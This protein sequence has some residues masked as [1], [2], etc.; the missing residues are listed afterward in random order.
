MLNL[1]E[2]RRAG[3]ILD[4][5]ISGSV[6]QR[7][8]QIDGYR[9][10]ILFY[11]PSET[12]RV[13]LSCRPGFARVSCLAEVPKAPHT[14]PSFVQY[15]RAHLGR[16]TCSGVSVA[17][18]DR[19]LQ[20]GIRTRDGAFRIYLSIL[21]A[22]SNVYLVDDRGVLLH[23]MRPLVRTRR[24][25]ALGQPWS[26]AGGSAPRAGSD[27]WADIADELFLEKIEE[28]YEQLEWQEEAQDLIRRIKSALDR[29]EAQLSR[30]SANLLEDLAAARSADEYRRRGELLKSVLHIIRPGDTSVSAIDHRTGAEV[31]IPLD[32][33]LSPAENLQACFVQ[34]QKGLRG[35]SS[36][37]AQLMTLEKAKAEIDGLNTALTG[38]SGNPLQN[39][40]A[41]RE[42]A[43]HRTVR[44][45]LAQRGS[46]RPVARPEGTGVRKSGIPARLQPRRFRTEDG[47]EIWVGRSDEGNDYLTTRMA[48]G[49][50]LFFHLEGSPGSHVILRTEGRTDPPPS[51][52][53]DA[54]ELAVHFSRLK[55]AGHADVHVVP[56]K[57]VRKPRG[58]RP[59]LVRVAGGRT[60]HLRRD[61]ARLENILASRMDE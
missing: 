17:E 48:R 10:V 31:S 58:A 11:R 16:G 14:P 39:L 7:F 28:T 29:E 18:E 32:P 41:L 46:R 23:S 38:Y 40:R 60:I 54:C 27:R 6:I 34:Y 19:L 1:T 22:R 4:Q 5:E 61:P 49:N 8:A 59:G 36:I 42:L 25:L 26:G 13:L 37:E 43:L 33:A 56:V 12:C 57:N 3:R 55:A 30:K 52:L 44:R 51:S 2:L 24:E 45:L 47:L 53:L 50:D 20:I 15:V 9:L 21:G 35:A